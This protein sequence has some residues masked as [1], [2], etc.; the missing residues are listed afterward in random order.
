MRFWK[1]TTTLDNLVPELGQ[2]VDIKEAE[3]AVIGSK[4]IPIREMPN[5]KAI[6]KCG[7]GTD[8]V[9]FEEADQLGVEILLPSEETQ[10]IIFEET[11]N[12]AVIS[13]LRALYS[14]TGNL[15]NWVKFERPFLGN[16]KVL[17]VGLGRIGN[18]V[19]QKLSS[20]VKVLT[21]DVLHNESE[22]LESLTR[23]ADVVTLHIP[24]NGNTDRFW[25]KEKLSWMKDGAI[26][27]N[28]SRGA[29]VDERD[30]L[31][32]I[33]S[34]RIKSVF[35]V[36]WKEPYHGPLRAYHPDY[37]FMSPHIASTCDDFLK[38]LARD[39]QEAVKRFS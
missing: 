23:Q 1:N 26:L 18:Y 19:K 8:N 2:I 21:F 16:R 4:P 30:L 36:Y 37:F 39:L 22:E 12:F 10:R 20:M 27:V 34:K 25:N 17:I 28:T 35:D 32:E 15:E 13:V 31:T 33:E 3:F 14:E 24:L 11:A 9:P 38:G 29:I 7:V 6:F 5:L